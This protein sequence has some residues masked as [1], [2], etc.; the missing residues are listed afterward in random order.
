MINDQVIML[1]HHPVN[2]LCEEEFDEFSTLM[3]R[4]SIIHLHGQKKVPDQ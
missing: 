2:W 1:S 3:E 4:Y